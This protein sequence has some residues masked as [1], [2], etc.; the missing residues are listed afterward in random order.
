MWLWNGA[1]TVRCLLFGIEGNY[2]RCIPLV[3]FLAMQPD[4]DFSVP[5]PSAKPVLVSY[6]SRIR[7]PSMIQLTT[8]NLQQRLVS[9]LVWNAIAIKVFYP[10]WHARQKNLPLNRADRHHSQCQSDPLILH[11]I[12]CPKFLQDQ[13]RKEMGSPAFPQVPQEST[14]YETQS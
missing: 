7:R 14:P 5:S 1:S 8:Y 11:A 12:R 3:I 2:L 4:S 6:S 9:R 10:T 13:V